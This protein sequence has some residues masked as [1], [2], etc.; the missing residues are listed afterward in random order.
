M[1]IYRTHR[2]VSDCRRSLHLLAR[3]STCTTVI[4]CFIA[5][6]CRQAIAPLLCARSKSHFVF[7]SFLAMRRL[8]HSTVMRCRWILHQGREGVLS[9]DENGIIKYSPIEFHRTLS[10]LFYIQLC[11]YCPFS[12]V[13][14]DLGTGCAGYAFILHHFG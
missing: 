6:R 13:R 7:S 12:I 9:I 11:R 14:S 1:K 3:L 8:G 2:S 10:S 5:R 4:V